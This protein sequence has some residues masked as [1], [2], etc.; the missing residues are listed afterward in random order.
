MSPLLSVCMITFNHAPFIAQAI[1]SVLE[2][3]TSF[4]IELVIGED[5]STDGTAAIIQ[6]LMAA[7]P[8]VIRARF[9]APN[10]GMM[11]NFLKTFGECRGKYV[12]ML[13][14]DDYWSDPEKLARQVRFLEEHPDYALCFHPVRIMENGRM[15][16]SDRFTR[17]VPETTTIRDLARGNYI[18]TCSV[19]YRRECLNELPDSLAHSPV[20]DY[21][22]HML[23]ARHGPI[24]RL[25]E[26][27][28]VY[29][30]H[31]G[32]VWSSH[33]GIEEKVLTYLECMIGYFAPEVDELLK[34]RHREVAARNFLGNLGQPDAITRLERAQRY[35][36]EAL[37]AQLRE[38]LPE[39]S[40]HPLRRVLNYIRKH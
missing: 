3:K 21:F 34:Q 4:P 26:T 6:D 39:R 38:M 5:H 35:G 36:G 31:A 25:P 12:A 13:E 2:Q 27:M 17:P 7:H 14:G 15:D 19:V 20:G 30:V 9:N 32:G 29:R 8:E 1:S 22:L 11:P 24:G 37:L 16:S 10:L 28:G 18:H 40:P 33:K 23:A